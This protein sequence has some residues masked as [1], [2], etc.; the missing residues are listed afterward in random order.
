MNNRRPLYLRL[1]ASAAAATLALTACGGGHDDPPASQTATSGTLAVS[2]MADAPSCGFD[3]VNVTIAKLRF[4]KDFNTDPSASGWTDLSFAPAKKIN[5]LN[6]ASVLSG[7]TTDLGQLTLPTGNYVQ[8]A[9]VLDSNTS[10]SA[11]TVVPVGSATEAPLQ[12]AAGLA[13]G[14]TVPIDLVVKDGQTTK[15]VVDMNACTSVQMN[16]SA[17]VLKPRPMPVPSDMNG[18]DGFVAKS[19]LGNNVVITA[20]YNGS[21]YTT[22][23]PNPTTGEFTLARLPAGSYDVVVQGK[24]IGTAVI[25]TVPVAAGAI[26]NVATAAA[27]IPLLTSAASTISGQ[28]TYTA[29][30]VAP[31]DGT[32]VRAS[33]TIPV[34]A[35]LG[36]TATSVTNRLQP[37]DLGTGNYA[38]TDLARIAPQYALYTPALPL[39]FTSVANSE[40]QG[41]YR[42]E[43]IATGYNNKTSSSANISVGSKDAPGVNITLP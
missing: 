32:W 43:S 2:L 33:Q 40:G 7:A 12:T 13:T 1:V 5:L 27:P 42:V 16:G 21:I 28:V 41:K 25:G 22:T 26:T 36:N 11:N 35:G 34:I 38:L 31:D 37:V 29:P 39:T 23:V 17:Y 15:L 20:Q 14:F 24:G 6:L 8:M 3:A 19:A 10:G 18:I 30:A 4:R 9:V